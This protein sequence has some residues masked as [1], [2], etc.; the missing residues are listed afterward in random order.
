MVGKCVQ[1]RLQF[2]KRHPT[3]NWDAV[4]EDVEV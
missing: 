3:P 2:S 4:V 1:V